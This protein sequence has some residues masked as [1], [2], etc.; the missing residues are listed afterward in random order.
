MVTHNGVNIK[1]VTLVRENYNFLKNIFY[2]NFFPQNNILKVIRKNGL[3][4]V[5]KSSLET[6]AINA[7]IFYSSL[8]PLADVNYLYVNIYFFQQFNL[9][10]ISM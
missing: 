2:S 3:P 4:S 1:E 8:F 10:Y 5:S 6:F 9:V 7:K